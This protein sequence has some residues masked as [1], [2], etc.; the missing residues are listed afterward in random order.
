MLQK[1]EIIEVTKCT[2]HI[3]PI[4]C[5]VRIK[6]EPCGLLMMIFKHRCLDS[7]SI[8]FH[9]CVFLAFIDPSELHYTT[10]ASSVQT[11]YLRHAVT[12]PTFVSHGIN[13]SPPGVAVRVWTLLQTSNFFLSF[14]LSL[15]PPPRG[16]HFHY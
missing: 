9:S 16:G 4:D 3:F 13:P 14:L 11:W 5:S 8:N 12:M 2:I 15:P 1:S 10:H 7:K 6:K